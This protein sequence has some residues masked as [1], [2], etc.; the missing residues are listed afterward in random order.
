MQLRPAKVKT[1]EVLGA[2][3]GPDR[4]K[5]LVFTAHKGDVL[6]IRPERTSRELFIAAKDLYAHLIRMQAG[7]AHLEKAR[8]RKAARARRREAQKIKR[9][10]RKLLT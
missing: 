2:A 3:Y 9:A 5:R 8:A 10:E 7:R 1:V 4:D 6:G